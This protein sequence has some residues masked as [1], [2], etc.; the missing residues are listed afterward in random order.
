MN[1]EGGDALDEI[2]REAR[3]LTHLP[4][5]EDD[6]DRPP[7]RDETPEMDDISDESISGSPSKPRTSIT[8]SFN[9]SDFD[10]KNFSCMKGGNGMTDKSNP[11]SR[12]ISILQEM[13]DYYTRINDT[14]RPIAYRK[15]IS[16]LRQQPNKITTSEE[17]FQLPCIGQRLSLK[18]EE[19]VTTDRLRRLENAKTEPGDHILQKF[20][21]I[22]GVGFSQANK[23]LHSGYSTLEDLKEHAHLTDNQLLG[24]KHYD[25]FQTA[26]S[27]RGGESPW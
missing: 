27:K 11:N 23:W 5:D 26:H 16:T 1:I 9:K 3:T 7:S 24:I 4:L 2:I 10:Q 13:A 22:Y 19:I 14:W 20:M 21:G 15:A 6:F 25:D 18:I 8:K 12:T 17:A